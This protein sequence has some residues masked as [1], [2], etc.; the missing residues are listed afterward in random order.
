MCAQP[1]RVESR[2]DSRLRW[3]SQRSFDSLAVYLEDGFN[4][5]G[6]AE[7]ERVSGWYVSGEFFRVLGRPF[8]RA[9]DRPD[10]P[11]VAVISEHLW[12][13]RF[14]TDPNIIGANLILDGKRFQVIG[15]TPPQADEEGTVDLFVLLGQSRYFGTFVTTQRGSHNFGCI[16]RLREGGTLGRAQTDL[17]VIRKN[18]AD[19]YPATNSAHGIKIVPYLDSVIGDYSSTL[20]LLEAAVACLL[21]ITC[22]NVANL[23]L[24]RSRERRREIS[25]RAAIGASRSRLMAQLLTESFVLAVV[26]SVIGMVLAYSTLGAIKALAPPDVGRF[27]EVQI[28]DGA[29]L[30]VLIVT[31]LTAQFCGL[32][33]ASVRNYPFECRLVKPRYIH[34]AG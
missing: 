5:S 2:R 14:G 11:A 17:E 15:V 27:Q 12:T 16:G 32:F 24:A 28:D 22:A 3:A 30:F 25:I 19:R 1:I 29:L 13:T 33:P 7:P 4:V 21:L 6:R 9:E 18:L 20:W 10:A 34:V 23:L 26:G 8:D 31:V